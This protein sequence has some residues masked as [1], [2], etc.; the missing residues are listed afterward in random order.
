MEK[1][2]LR[3]KTFHNLLMYFLKFSKELN[4]IPGKKVNQL[5]TCS[6]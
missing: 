6:H 3:A 1:N 4:S 2:L 5:T